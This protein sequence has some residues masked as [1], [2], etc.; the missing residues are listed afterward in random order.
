M[1]ILQSLTWLLT[2][3]LFASLASLFLLG[4]DRPAI[5]LSGITSL[6]GG[7][8]DITSGI[9]QLHADVTLV[10]RFASPFELA[11]LT[12]RMDSLLV[13]MALATPLLVVVCPLCSST[14]MREYEGK[15][16]AATGFF[17]NIFI[18]SMVA[19]LVMGNAP[20][21]IVLFEMMPLS[22]WFLVTAR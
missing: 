3:Y 18:A 20:W 10:A 12:L 1:D 9:T 14:H 13:S 19:L 11:D 4:L 17:M 15:S 2:L 16:A 7:A 22:S 21:S 6:V 5:K 8:I